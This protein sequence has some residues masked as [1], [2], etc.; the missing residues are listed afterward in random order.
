[1]NQVMSNNFNV[2]LMKLLEEDDDDD[3]CLIDGTPLDDHCV[4]LV[5][6][7]KFNYLSL[8]Q[9]VKVQ[10]KYNNLE[11]QKLSSYQIK[12]PYC[13]KINNGVLP[14]IESLCKTKMRGINWPASKVLKT[15]KCCAIIK[16]G[17]RKGEICGKLCAGK[18]CPRHAKLA[19]KAKT[20]AK[21]N[22]NVNKKIKNVSGKTC[23]AVIK[24]GKR[25]G[26]I[27]GCKCKNNENMCGRHISKKKVLNTIIS[28]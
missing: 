24:S 8:L 13:R 27:C 10:K 12:C 22:V 26:E 11:V 6:K 15:K 4:E 25:K 1:M 5:C 3:V 7:H 2:E 18:L 23:I 17:K 21:A 19:E 9:E 16:S 14:Y 28:I 20:K